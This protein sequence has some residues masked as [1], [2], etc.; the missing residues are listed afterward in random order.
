M[1]H[2]A[3]RALAGDSEQQNQELSWNTSSYFSVCLQDTPWAGDAHWV[4]LAGLG[5]G[6]ASPQWAAWLI[7]IIRSIFTILMKNLA[8]NKDRPF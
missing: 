6:E 3:L 7:I 8:C 5:H 2:A 4:W 1:S